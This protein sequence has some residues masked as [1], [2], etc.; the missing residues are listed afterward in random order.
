[1]EKKEERRTHTC[2]GARK[3]QK[4]LLKTSKVAIIWVS[5]SVVERGSSR[6]PH[7]TSGGIVIV[8]LPFKSISSI[9]ITKSKSKYKAQNI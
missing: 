7:H 1:M 9:F 6:N 5:E 4:N 2:F 8:L 3:L